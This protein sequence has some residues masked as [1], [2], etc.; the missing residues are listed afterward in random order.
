MYNM[1]PHF[2]CF[3]I[4]RNAHCMVVTFPPLCD[5]SRSLI[6]A[7]P[8]S[9]PSRLSDHDALGRYDSFPCCRRGCLFAGSGRWG[10]RGVPFLQR[11]AMRTPQCSH[12]K[13]CTSYGNSVR[14]S[15]TRWYCVKTT[16]R[17]MVLFTRSDSK[18]CLVLWKPKNIHQGRPL[19]PEILARSDLPPPEGSEFDTFC[20]VAPQ[21]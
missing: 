3:A 6:I 12:C 5:I 2:H 19:P 15:Y 16:A 8:R 20:L 13:R 1:H 11:A 21:P 18:M 7:S 4:E 17:S 14:L 9:R 10:K